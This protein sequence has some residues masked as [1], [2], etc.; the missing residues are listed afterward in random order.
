VPWGVLLLLGGGFALAG[1][2]ESSGLSQW[3]GDRFAGLQGVPTLV[4]LLIM[5]V[6]LAVMTEV[7]S[8]GATA[9]LFVPLMGSVAVTLGHDPLFVML[10]ATLAVNCA[11]MLPAATPPQQ[12]HL[13]NRADHHRGT[14][15]GPG[16]L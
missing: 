3:V 2:V 10:A 5:V 9:I 14:W 16:L 7:T 11:F 13:R 1:A 12:H 8:T 6:A 15:S 4:F